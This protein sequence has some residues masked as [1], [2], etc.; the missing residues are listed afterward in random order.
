MKHFDRLYKTIMEDVRSSKKQVIK[1][2]VNTVE[3]AISDWTID[4]DLVDEG[5]RGY[6]EEKLRKFAEFFLPICPKWCSHCESADLN[7]YEEDSAPKYVPMIN[8]DQII[9]I[10]LLPNGTTVRVEDSYAPVTDFRNWEKAKKYI[11]EQLED[12]GVDMTTESVNKPSKRKVIKESEDDYSL[13]SILERRFKQLNIDCDDECFDY[14]ST[15]ENKDELGYSLEDL[16]EIDDED[17]KIWA[18]GIINKWKDLNNEEYDDDS[19]FVAWVKELKQK[20][21]DK[22]NIIRK[23]LRD[24]I[25]DN[26]NG[27]LDEFEDN[28]CL[29]DPKEWKEFGADLTGMRPCPNNLMPNDLRYASWCE[30]YMSQYLWEVAALFD[31]DPDD[32]EDIPEPIDPAKIENLKTRILSIRPDWKDVESKINLQEEYEC[33]VDEFGENFTDDDI[34]DFLNYYYRD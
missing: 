28:G 17:F 12:E 31:L 2:S 13:D 16:N 29:L 10:M 27:Y 6:T 26:Y 22:Y 1:E 8:I 20:N 3:D 33:I 7:E 4:V 9:F 23:N 15:L 14:F 18:T 21:M 32:L 19:D 34:R 30:D 25:E 11:I 24:Y 5:K